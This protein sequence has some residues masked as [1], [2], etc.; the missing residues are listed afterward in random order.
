MLESIDLGHKQ[1]EAAP[2]T[3]VDAL[4][5]WPHFPPISHFIFLQSS[6]LL[7][8]KTAYCWYLHSEHMI[9]Y[10]RSWFGTPAQRRSTWATNPNDTR[11]LFWLRSSGQDWCG[12]PHSILHQ[13]P[14][15]PGTFPISVNLWTDSLLI[16][17]GTSVWTLMSVSSNSTLWTIQFSELISGCINWLVIIFFYE[18][19][20][21]SSEEA[22]WLT[23]K[24]LDF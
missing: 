7:L 8:R 5:L 4:W 13:V 22:Y 16:H 24:E 19:Y 18:K 21:I 23:S 3:A 20:P 10:F 9:F 2:L 1:H 11:T 12:R 15:I 17:A 14:T 6:L